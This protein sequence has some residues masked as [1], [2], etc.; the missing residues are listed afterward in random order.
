M[1]MPILV[2]AWKVRRLIMPQAT[3]RWVTVSACDGLGVEET[4]YVS[5]FDGIWFA[6][7]ECLLAHTVRVSST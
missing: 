7:V 6:G 2:K 3:T 4:S 5:T 1:A